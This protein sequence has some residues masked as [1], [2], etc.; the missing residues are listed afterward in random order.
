MEVSIQIHIQSFPVPEYV[1]LDRGADIT[2]PI[3]LDGDRVSLTQLDE[4]VLSDLCNEFRANVF[5]RAGKVDPA[6][7]LTR[8]AQ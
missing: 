7:V 4:K 8:G 6:S 5:A 2:Q 3:V 1:K